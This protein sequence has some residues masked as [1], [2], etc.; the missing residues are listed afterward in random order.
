MCG[1][2]Y[3]NV[4]HK[5]YDYLYTNREIKLC[6]PHTNYISNPSLL[7]DNENYKASCFVEE[8]D[9]FPGYV[10][11]SLAE[12]KANNINWVHVARMIDDK[13][14]LSNS[15]IMDSFYKPISVDKLKNVIPLQEDRLL[16]YIPSF[17]KRDKNGP[18][19]TVD[20]ANFY[21]S[22]IKTDNVFC[23]HYDTWPSSANSFITR[24]KP[25]NWPINSML[26]NIQSQGCE[27]AAVGH[28]D[29]KTNDIHWRISFPSERSLFLDLTDVQI[30]FYALIKKI[31]Q[32]KLNTSQREVVSSFHIKHVM[33]WCVELCSCQWVDSNYINYLNICLT[34]LIQ[35]IHVRHIPHYIIESRNLFNS[36]MTEKVSEE[37]VDVLSKCDTTR[38]FTLDAFNHGFEG[39]HFSNAL[40][41]QECLISIIMACFTFCCG[42]F[43]SFCGIHLYFGIHAYHIMPQKAC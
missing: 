24:R 25:N 9:N 41:K 5:D 7:H 13:L 42:N 17:D 37:I 35:M 14:Y 36:K 19:Y 28:H 10:K 16:L 38:V 11:L 33:F 27:V 15:L 22:T 8:D 30:L 23:I 2:I 20:Y 6:T 18:A 31:L 3:D 1:G 26:E 40:L 21:G 12:V 29:S 43:S 32:E 34:K 4:K 39:T